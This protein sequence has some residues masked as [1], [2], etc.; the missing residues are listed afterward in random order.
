MGV[1]ATT[2]LHGAAGCIRTDFVTS[3]SPPR[4]PKRD[5]SW[6]GGRD[7]QEGLSLPPQVSSEPFPTSPLPSCSSPT[8]S[9]RHGFSVAASALAT[10]G[11]IGAGSIGGVKHVAALVAS[12]PNAMWENKVKEVGGG[13]R[14]FTR[15][16][17]GLRYLEL[18]RG[19]GDECCSEGASATVGW[20]LRRS[21]G[22]FIDSSFSVAPDPSRAM[23]ERFGVGE[24]SDLFFEPRGNSTS[25]SGVI[26]GIKEAVLGMRVGGTR[27]VI[28]PPNL[29]YEQ[30]LDLQPMPN[31][32]GRQRQ[33]QRC[34]GQDLI[35]EIRLSNIK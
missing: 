18:V 34:R 3:G 28:V 33:V 14:D 4:L 27:R 24:M 25:K 19:N 15:T 6:R 22:Y 2:A 31:D 8:F 26:A 16:E 21:N 17:S 20:I 5:A 11:G 7:R 12:E 30:S 23:D 29:G 32:W 35:F 9:R 13:I 10:F 1:I